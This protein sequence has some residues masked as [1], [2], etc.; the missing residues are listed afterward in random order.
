MVLT[1]EVPFARASPLESW[2]KKTKNDFPAPRT[3]NPQLSERTDWAIRRAMSAAPKERPA[4]CREFME[5]LTG[6]AWRTRSGNG[7]D[8]GSLTETS[9]PRG[10]TQPLPG[11][12]DLWYLVY[13]GANGESHT[14]KGTTDSI[15]QNVKAGYLGDPTA[16]LVCRTKTG[17]FVSLRSVPEFRDLVIAP[18]PVA[19][20]TSPSGRMARPGT[21]TAP[22]VTTPAP[23]APATPPRTSAP[24]GRVTS[25]PA[26]GVQTDRHT[27]TP[28]TAASVKA[29]ESRRT[30]P[31][32]AAKAPIPTAVKAKTDWL[33]WVVV[34]IAILSATAG[35]FFFAR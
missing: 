9:A 16:V 6:Q 29:E 17:Q 31:A 12:P 24:A 33:P 5:D 20:T 26:S 32:T 23:G 27:V 18:A 15:R 22:V 3:V 34:G 14:V 2:L 13:K 35:A 30:V 25:D 19:V 21:G 11:M 28:L 8:S 4:S 7:T 10:P 1:G